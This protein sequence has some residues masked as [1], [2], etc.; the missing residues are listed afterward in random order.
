VEWSGVEW[1]GVEWSGV[2]W[3]GVFE[4]RLQQKGFQM[5][6]F[7]LI[8]TLYLQVYF[9]VLVTFSFLFVGTGIKKTVALTNVKFWPTVIF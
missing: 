8:K 7:Q 2:E 4:S 3:S 5:F 9:S 1:S 6:H